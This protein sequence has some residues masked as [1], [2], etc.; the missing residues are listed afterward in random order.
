MSPIRYRVNCRCAVCNAIV[1]ADFAMTLY[2]A[3]THVQKCACG[4][5]MVFCVPAVVV[6]RNGTRPVQAPPQPPTLLDKEMLA[7][8]A[9]LM[10]AGH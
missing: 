6:D 2:H 10:L 4:N 1:G 3:H 8:Q 9:L 7:S 5:T